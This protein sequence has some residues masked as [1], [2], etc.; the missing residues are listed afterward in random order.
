MIKKL[1]NKNTYPE[2]IIRKTTYS[3]SAY[4]KWELN[5]LKEDWEIVIYSEENILH[6]FDR[7]LND[8]ILRYKIDKET[9]FLREKII[10][11][12]LEKVYN[13]L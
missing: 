13:G 2:V 8:N 4:S 7:L 3:L 12:S 9:L 6:I 5:E 10:T 1:L 11:K